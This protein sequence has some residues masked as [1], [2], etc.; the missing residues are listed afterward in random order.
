MPILTRALAGPFLHWCPAGAYSQVVSCPVSRPSTAS[1]LIDSVLNNSKNL[2]HQ[3]NNYISP[4]RLS[5]LQNLSRT[6]QKNEISM[7][8]DIDAAA[9]MSW[10]DQCIKL[11]AQFCL[12]IGYA[13][14]LCIA[15]VIGLKVC[16]LFCKES[17]NSNKTSPVIVVD[18]GSKSKERNNDLELSYRTLHRHLE[19]ANDYT[20]N[21]DRNTDN[22]DNT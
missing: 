18:N 14:L 20:V 2:F 4:E 8:R 6:A 10:F 9:N 5:R 7:Q 16:G 12:A 11:L 1:Q 3:L 17:C 13:L 22:N 15:F 21:A 19:E